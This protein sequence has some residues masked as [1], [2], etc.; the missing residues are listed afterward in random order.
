M[1]KTPVQLSPLTYYLH[2]KGFVFPINHGCETRCSHL[3]VGE[4]SLLHNLER[5]FQIHKRFGGAHA[6]YIDEQG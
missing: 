3:T 2:V 1:Y 6:Y 5:L 4:K